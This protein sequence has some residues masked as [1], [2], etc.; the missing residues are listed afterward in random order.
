M[1]KLC[2]IIFWVK[3][4]PLLIFMCVVVSLIIFFSLIT[5]FIAPSDFV[6]VTFDLTHPFKAVVLKL[7][8]GPP[9]WDVEPLQV[10]WGWLREKKYGINCWIESGRVFI[11]A[12]LAFFLKMD[13]REQF[14]L[15]TAHSLTGQQ[16]VSQWTMDNTLFS[17]SMSKIYKQT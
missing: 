1:P 2:S 8:G 6:R 13:E 11:V 12:I 7:W 15:K 10:R 3:G 9:W 16:V 5:C 4:L 14:W 17:N